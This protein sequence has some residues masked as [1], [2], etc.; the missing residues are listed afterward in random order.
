MWFLKKQAPKERPEQDRLA[1][2]I[3]V[4]II[5]WQRGVADRLNGRARRYD[6]ATQLR[7]FWLGCVLAVA[8]LICSVLITGREISLPH[9]HNTRL[10]THIG[11]SSDGPPKKDLIPTDS[12]THKIKT[13]GNDH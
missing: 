3:A 8:A 13:H 6:R 10:P 2:S 1:A 12:L 5:N 9:I 11:Q 4:R 7:W